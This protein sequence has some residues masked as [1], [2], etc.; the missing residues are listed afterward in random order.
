MAFSEKLKNE[1]ELYCNNHLPQDSWYENEFSF[2]QGLDLK[3]RI[4]TEFKAI[5]FAY[6]LYEGIEATNE[7]LLFEVRNQIL[8]YASIYEAVIE[9]VLN[10]YYSDTVEF[11]SL[12][13]HIIPM[14]IS[15][16]QSKQ[17]ILQN[18]L[19]H[20]GKDVA[21][22]TGKMVELV[23]TSIPIGVTESGVSTF[24]VLA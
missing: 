2:I 5:R 21:D 11:D 13:H 8:A 9:N 3:N 12:M 19:S 1:I 16:P 18:V 4:I 22:L 17:D 7:N 23:G 15:I 20:D 6:K 14:K 24:D 10:S